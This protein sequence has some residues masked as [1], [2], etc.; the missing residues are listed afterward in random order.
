[1]GQVGALFRKLKVIL[2]RS[3]YDRFLSLKIFRIGI[4]FLK[5][6]VRD[7][8]SLP[9]NITSKSAVK[10]VL[11]LV[12]SDYRQSID[13][14]STRIRGAPRTDLPICGKFGG[15]SAVPNGGAQ[16]RPLRGK[17]SPPPSSL[18]ALRLPL[19]RQR[20]HSQ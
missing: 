18:P 4:H 3:L 12:A 1:M 11:D 19:E 2:L 10:Y 5:E 13:T 6:S 7:N 14:P 17:S 16:N 15:N 9:L 8:L 20:Q